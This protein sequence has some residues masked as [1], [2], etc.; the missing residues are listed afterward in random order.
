MK[1]IYQGVLFVAF[2]LIAIYGFGGSEGANLIVAF[3]ALMA[4][5]VLMAKS[6][7]L[8]KPVSKE[9]YKKYYDHQM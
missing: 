3:S 9:E 1:K 4:V 6:G 8:A 2:M 7:M 5:A